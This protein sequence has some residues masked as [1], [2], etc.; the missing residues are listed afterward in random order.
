MQIIHGKRG[1]GKT[2][3]LIQKV[4]E[5]GGVL[6][7]PTQRQK[8]FYI[9]SKILA[10]DQ[11]ITFQ[12]KRQLPVGWGESRKRYWIDQVDMLIEEMFGPGCKGF[13]MDTPNVISEC[14]FNDR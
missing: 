7:V 8:R 11:V 5:F 10:K 14:D 3:K 1:S 2:T 6:V 13:S 12:E 4:Q 9:D